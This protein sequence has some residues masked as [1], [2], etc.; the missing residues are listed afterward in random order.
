MNVFK[1]IT[2]YFNDEIKVLKTNAANLFAMVISYC[3]KH[4]LISTASE[5]RFLLN[6]KN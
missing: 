6:D 1:I 4:Y 2:V 5:K 3:L